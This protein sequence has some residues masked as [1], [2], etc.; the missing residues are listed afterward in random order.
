MFG[1]DL[2]QTLQNAIGSLRA[3]SQDFS[4]I[5]K[6]TLLQTFHETGACPTLIHTPPWT[7]LRIKD[8][9]IGGWLNL[10]VGVLQIS[11]WGVCHI[12]LVVL[13]STKKKKGL[14]NRA[15]GFGLRLCEQ[16]GDKNNSLTN[17]KISANRTCPYYLENPPDHS[18]RRSHQALRLS[19]L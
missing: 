2:K 1:N 8:V 4:V 16:S 19:W 3:F 5:P 10:G 7:A 17:P 11:K 14:E 18:L 6:F 9:L 15:V 12:D 13:W